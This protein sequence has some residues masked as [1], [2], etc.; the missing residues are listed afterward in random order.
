MAQHN[1]K[2]LLDAGLLVTVNS[3]DPAY[4]GGYINDNFV[5]V[6]SA[7]RLT[8]QHARQLARNS[9]TA[10][11]LDPAS[12]RLYLQEADEFFKGISIAAT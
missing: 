7:L 8:V 5:A 11:F 4:F 9:F 6:F 3:D 1:I 2:A 12:K 10:S